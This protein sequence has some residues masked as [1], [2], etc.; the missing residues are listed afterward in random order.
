MNRINTQRHQC[1]IGEL[2]LGSFDGRL[3]LIEFGDT[4]TRGA[5]DDRIRKK[6][7]AE[8][9]QH[10]HGIL[11]KTRRQLD[12]YFRGRRREFDIP[13]LTVGTGF[14]KRVWKALMSI[15]CGATSTYGQIAES[16]GNLGAARAVGSACGVNPISIIVP[17][18]RVIGSN[19]E[20]AGYGGGLALKKWLLK[21]EQGGTRAHMG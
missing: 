20:L 11:E 13:L 19:G 16:I 15:P 2:L 4:G 9:V 8:F 17:C 3:C 7:D 5:V 1:E 10:D 14:Q 21:L 6:L 12:E 18:H